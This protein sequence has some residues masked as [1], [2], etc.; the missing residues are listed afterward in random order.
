M[1]KLIA[2]N[3]WR[4]L[5]RSAKKTKTKSYVAVAYFGKGGAELLPLHKGSILLVDASEGAVKAGQ[6]SPSELL[7]LYYK[8][9]HIYSKACLHAKIYI[10]GNNVFV[11]SAN[12][13]NHSKNTLKEI[14]FKTDDRTVIKEAKE[15]ILSFCHISLGDEKLK[16]LQKLYRPPH[17]NGT[18]RAKYKKPSTKDM[19]YPLYTVQLEPHDYDEEEQR[20]SNKG[21]TELKNNRINKS[22]HFVDEF[23]IEGR[24]SP[25]KNDYIVMVE[26]IGNNY[27][28][29]PVGQLIHKHAWNSGNVKKTLCFLEIPNKYRKNLKTINNKLTA[30]ERKNIK[31][32]KKQSKSFTDKML[33]LWKMK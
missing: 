18:K 30:A 32:D 5:S 26:E 17:F 14:L 11:G 2:R 3:I 6:T 1:N 12:V 19:D 31:K 27:F 24:F 21:K 4:N 23:I 15:F 16:R 20:H 22:R 8:G 28:V 29:N 25:K 33:S 10:L 7:K 9:V 13:S